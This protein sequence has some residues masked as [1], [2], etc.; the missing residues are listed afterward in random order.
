MT[1]DKKIEDE[2]ILPEFDLPK[3]FAE[4]DFDIEQHQ[5]DSNNLEQPKQ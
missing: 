2:E 4:I 1:T 5:K 3:P